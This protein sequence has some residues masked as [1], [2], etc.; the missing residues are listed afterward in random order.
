MDVSSGND[1]DDYDYN[2]DTCPYILMMMAIGMMMVTI[3]MIKVILDTGGAPMFW[4]ELP[5]LCETDNTKWYQSISLWKYKIQNTKYKMIPIY[6]SVTVQNTKYK[7]IPIIINLGIFSSRN[8]PSA[9]S[10]ERNFD[11]RFL[12]EIFGRYQWWLTWRVDGRTV[13]FDFKS[14]LWTG[15]RSVGGTNFRDWQISG[16]VRFFNWHLFNFDHTHSIPFQSFHKN[17]FPFQSIIERAGMVE[18]CY[19][20]LKWY[21]RW[22][23]VIATASAAISLMTSNSF[24]L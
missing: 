4:W 24:Q 18:R 2:S 6:L 8:F 10:F 17:T 15:T 19:L 23:L 5:S 16:Q 9:L 1:D 22:Y 20:V 7:M 13:E 3:M 12:K 14:F 21:L 11:L